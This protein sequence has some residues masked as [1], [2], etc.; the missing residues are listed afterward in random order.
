MCLN[1]SLE[2]TEGVWSF[3]LLNRENPKSF[4]MN[5]VLLCGF[6]WSSAQLFLDVAYYASDRSKAL[7]ILKYAYSH[8]KV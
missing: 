1:D 2:I 7:E 4:P 5:L 6:S 8:L 3:K